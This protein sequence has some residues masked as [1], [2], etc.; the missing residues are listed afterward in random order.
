M[1]KKIFSFKNIY[2]SVLVWLF[3][4]WICLLLFLF[5]Q[6]DEIRIWRINYEQEKQG[7]YICKTYNCLREKILLCDKSFLYTESTPE[8]FLKEFVYPEN[9]K[10]IYEIL[11]SDRNGMKCYFGTEL[12]DEDFIEKIKISNYTKIKEIKDN[13]NLISY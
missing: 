9:G 2:I 4:F 11:K 3:V 7:F 8:Y 6:R 1:F 12:I 13:C 10:C 5:I